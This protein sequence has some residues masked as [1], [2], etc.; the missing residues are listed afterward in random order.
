ML[1]F[2]KKSFA[3][4]ALLLAGSLSVTGQAFAI[5]NADECKAEVKQVI[6]NLLKANVSAD[7]MTSIDASIVAAEAHCAGEKFSEAEAELNKARDMIKSA[8]QN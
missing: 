1:N 7:A 6:Q 5:S 3:V 2:N 8:A 4:A